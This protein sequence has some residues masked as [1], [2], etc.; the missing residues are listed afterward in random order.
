MPKDVKTPPSQITVGVNA[1]RQVVLSIRAED[2]DSR[3]LPRLFQ[4]RLLPKV[5]RALARD[6]LDY[7]QVAESELPLA[8]A[9]LE[10]ANG[11]E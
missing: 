7:S 2:E 11:A 5:A 4:A 1:A 8:D 3:M 6:L 9:L 10:K